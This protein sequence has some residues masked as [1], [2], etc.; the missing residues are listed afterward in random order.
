MSSVT[1]TSFPDGRVTY[2]NKWFVDG[3]TRYSTL[4]QAINYT[5][6]AMEQ[7]QRLEINKAY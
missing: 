4:S 2:Y 3:Y 1:V 6:T 5:L 7:T